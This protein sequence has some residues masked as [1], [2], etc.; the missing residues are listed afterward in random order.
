[1]EMSLMAFVLNLHN[2]ES[3]VIVKC[4]QKWLIQM[5]NVYTL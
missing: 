1:M 4:I 2:R 3:L 5:G